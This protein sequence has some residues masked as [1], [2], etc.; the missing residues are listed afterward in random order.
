MVSY[1]Q[2]VE[3][4]PE[5]YEQA[6]E[7]WRA[8]ARMIRERADDLAVAKT[9]LSGCWGQGDA[10]QA[11]QA[12]VAGL[13]NRL[14]AA[15]EALMSLDQT[16]CD[17]ASGIRRA[18]AMLDQASA[19]A[20]AH[21]VTIGANGSVTAPPATN[22]QDAASL[23]AAMDGVG[24]EIGA[25]VR[26]ATELDA[27]TTAALAA[28]APQIAETM[29]APNLAAIPQPGADPRTVKDW[30]G[31][32]NAAERRWLIENRPDLVGRLN[33]VPADARD[34]ANRIN[35]DEAQHSLEQ[36]KHDIEARLVALDDPA[37]WNHNDPDPY[38]IAAAERK[39]LQAELAGVTGTLGGIG[40]IVA[41]LDHPG[42]GQDRGYL[43]GFDAQGNGRAIVATGNP[44]TAANV[45]TYVPGTGAS[46]A[47]VSGDIHRA[48]ITAAYANAYN[49]SKETVGVLWLGYDAPQSIVP[50][51][52][53][54]SFA[55]T[56]SADLSRF[57]DG[58]RVT[59]DGAP[60]H[61]TVIGHSYGS[62]VVGMTARDQ[63]INAND[64]VFVGS[65][66]VG[67]DNAAALH[68]DGSH[69]WSGHIGNDP[70]LKAANVHQTV[71]D[72]AKDLVFGG[73][74][75]GDQARTHH[76]LLYGV[77]PDA[78][79]FG[80]QHF[81]AQDGSPSLHAHSE[82]WDANSTTLK[83]MARIVAGQPDQVQ[84]VRP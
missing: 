59:H 68:V 50:G 58:L 66:G 74:R 3:A 40:A 43:L 31:G 24:L 14:D 22:D 51:A 47:G 33:G 49:P 60:S 79:S 48:D 75:L 37:N 52:M 61:N 19:T 21:G 38:G 44:D 10:E 82:Y 77:N 62:T 4:K 83:N 7:V 25:A 16:L 5:P 73:D 11:A 42:P 30:W 70:I 18:K 29:T 28:L 57:Q 56:A 54:A 71:T 72:T 55:H 84:V 67:V 46:L 8:A 27:Q 41:R 69:V 76:H 32:L 20:Q 65:P 26:F 6:A 1:Q 12:K 36:R 39:R 45:V 64:V 63:N 34:Q 13:V 53:D 15:N 35:L 9:R 80:G 23:S 78:T 2:L 81:T 17:H